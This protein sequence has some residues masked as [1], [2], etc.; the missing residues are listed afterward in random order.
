MDSKTCAFCS[1]EVAFAASHCAACGAKQ[2]G[3]TMHRGHP[4][5]ILAGV[6]AGLS[7]QLGIDAVI[8]RI[9]FGIAGFVSLGTVFWAYVLLWV[10]MPER[11]GMPSPASRMMRNVKSAFTSSDG[12]PTRDTAA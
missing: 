7:D 1:A 2:P 4:D 3:S 12:I 8:I 10:L 6:C 11:P 5:K 9:F